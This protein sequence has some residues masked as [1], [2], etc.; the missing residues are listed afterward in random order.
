MSESHISPEDRDRAERMLDRFEENPEE[1]EDVTDEFLPHKVQSL[2]SDWLREEFSQEE[3]MDRLEGFSASEIGQFFV[4]LR[5]HYER[6]LRHI[7]EAAQ[8][9]IPT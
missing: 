8:T 5:E 1:F 3:L 9:D 7:R 2:F 4:A 6:K